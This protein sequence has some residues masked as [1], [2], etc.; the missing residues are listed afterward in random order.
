MFGWEGEKSPGIGAGQ[1]IPPGSTPTGRTDR[2]M[3]KMTVVFYLLEVG[4]MMQV[5]VQ[6]NIYSF[7]K[8]KKPR[9]G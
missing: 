5:L 9:K 4:G 8:E 3:V 2:V 6:T 1:T 7:V